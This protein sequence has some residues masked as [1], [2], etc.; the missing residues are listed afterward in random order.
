MHLKILANITSVLSDPSLRAY[1][2]N[3]RVITSKEAV[4]MTLL[5]F[6]VN[7]SIGVFM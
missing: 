5:I 4:E 3:E 7:S 1:L 2:H 6:A